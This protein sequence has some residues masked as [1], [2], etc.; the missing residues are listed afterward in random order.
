VAS[1]PLSLGNGE[2]D[3]ART[4]H[5]ARGPSFSGGKP[6]EAFRESTDLHVNR[7]PQKLISTRA[8]VSRPEQ[9]TTEVYAIEDGN[10]RRKHRIGM[11]LHELTH[12]ARNS[13]KIIAV[14]VASKRGTTRAR[15][16]KRLRKE[17]LFAQ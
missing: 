15:R 12:P 4:A 2:W 11:L 9:G 10:E 3:I 5:R 14:K 16:V 6:I 1:S 13:C 17:S 7:T 8:K